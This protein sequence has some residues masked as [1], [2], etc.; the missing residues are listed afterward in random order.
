MKANT[1]GGS[2]DPVMILRVHLLDGSIESFTL[3]DEAEAGQIWER[4]DPVRLFAQQRLVIAG[5]RSKS[6]FA[7]SGVTRIDFVQNCFA[8]WGF[9][10]GY[11]DVVELSEAE[12][13]KHAHLDQPELMTRREN[14]TP[15]GDLL[16]SFLRLRFTNGKPVFL[17]V[18]LPVKLPVESQS[19]MRFLLSKAG[20]HMRL[21]GGGVGVVNLAHL[22][23]YTVYPGVAQL[24][25]DAWLAEAILREEGHGGH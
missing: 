17:M 3:S 19:F 10:E 5:T 16:V 13:R 7:S 11:S 24:P 25:P 18:E 8:C 2:N 21:R 1:I 20:F 23:G 14:P 9:P 22:A 12:F 4:V 6:V 15:V